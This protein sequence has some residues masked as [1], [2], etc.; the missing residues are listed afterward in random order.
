MDEFLTVA[1]V[2]EI[3]GWSEATIYSKVCRREI[4]HL[5]LGRSVRIRR[6]ALMKLFREVP[7]RKSLLDLE[8]L[9][10]KGGAQ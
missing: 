3:T 4:P 10:G 6:S 7:V 1:K 9:K 8:G 2:A 5:K